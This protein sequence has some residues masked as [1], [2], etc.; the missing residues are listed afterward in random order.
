MDAVK[1]VR[2]VSVPF[3]QVNIDTDQLT[4]ARF[5]GRIS[6][7]EPMGDILFHDLRYDA[8]GSERPEFILNQTPYR[9]A[10]VLVGNSN[11]G[12]GSSRETAVWALKDNGFDAVIAPSFGDI[13]HSNAA[14]NGLIAVRL[15][16]AQCAEIRKVLHQQ[17]GTELTVDL[18]TQSV[19][20][21]DGRNEAMTFQFDAFQKH[22]LTQGLDDIS[23]TLEHAGT[24]DQYEIQH[25][26]QLRWL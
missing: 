23:I 2:A 12:C 3:D 10:K 14:K 22:C 26:L 20:V 15:S 25:R 21:H 19:F 6:A 5:M 9:D 1:L 7:R 4:P 8:S 17:P 11:F 13:F 18:E 16:A 24:I